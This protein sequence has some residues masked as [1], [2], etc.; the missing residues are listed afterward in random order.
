MAD[1]DPLRAAEIEEKL[2]AVWRDR[3]VA[4]QEARAQA[5]SKT[6]SGGTTQNGNIRKTRVI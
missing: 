3:W 6:D 4:L 1:N 5:Q 2:S